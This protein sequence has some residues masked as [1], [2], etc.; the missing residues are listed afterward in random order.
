MDIL[1]VGDLAPDFS[2]TGEDGKVVS[3]ADFK[4]KKLV[5]YF[6]PKDNTPGCTAEACNLRD[7]YG[8]LQKRGYQIIGVSPDNEKSHKRFAEKHSLPFPLIPDVEK[9]IIQKYNA[10]GEKKI[11]GKTYIGMIRKT[12]LISEDG[13]IEQIIEKVRTKTHAKQIMG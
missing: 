1:K 6:Y 10:W 8:E 2:Y 11:F 9:E 4:G 13:R 3:L 12:F 7:N 5:L